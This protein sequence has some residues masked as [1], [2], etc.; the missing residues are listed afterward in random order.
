M[1]EHVVTLK[2]EKGRNTVTPLFS[3]Y[4]FNSLD[5]GSLTHCCLLDCTKSNIDHRSDAWWFAD[6]GVVIYIGHHG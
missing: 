6:S 4:P 3:V 5:S 1:V 2:T